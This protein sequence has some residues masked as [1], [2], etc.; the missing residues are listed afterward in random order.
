MCSV[1]RRGEID[2]ERRHLSLWVSLLEWTVFEK[3]KAE[4]RQKHLDVREILLNRK[5]AV[6][7]KFDA[8]SQKLLVDAKD[9]YSAAE[10]QGNAT[11]R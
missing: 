2:D 8:K 6:A 5:Q 11:I 9:M 3:E 7:E 10:A 1:G 4:V